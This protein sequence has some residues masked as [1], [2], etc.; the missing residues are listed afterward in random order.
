MQGGLVNFTLDSGADVTII[1]EATLIQMKPKPKLK[2]VYTKLTSPGGQL[3]CLGQFVA[4]AV[5]DGQ[6]LHYRVIVAKTMDNLLSHNVAVK[7]GFMKRFY[8]DE[9]QDYG[10][11]GILQCDPV[12]I[13]LWDNATPYSAWC[14]FHCYLKLKWKCD[15]WR[16]MELLSHR[17]DRVVCT[18]GSCNGMEKRQGV[19]LC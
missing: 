3:S 15:T 1:A 14:Q 10:D 17:A 7:M 19:Y 4:R 13:L 2:P 11:I 18:R 5:I 9:I 16:T 8:V 12:K 6:L